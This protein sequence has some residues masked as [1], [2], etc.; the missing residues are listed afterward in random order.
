MTITLFNQGA[1]YGA[2]YKMT[3][4]LFNKQSNTL[5]TLNWDM[6]MQDK[7]VGVVGERFKTHTAFESYA[8]TI[9]VQGRT[10]ITK[11]IQFISSNNFQLQLGDYDLEIFVFSGTEKKHSSSTLK[12]FKVTQNDLDK[13]QEV[14]NNYDSENKISRSAITFILKD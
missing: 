6:F 10:A 13:W 5:T 8:E 9:V 4:E 3:A 7:N 2:V 14:S 12:K 11:K 1:Q